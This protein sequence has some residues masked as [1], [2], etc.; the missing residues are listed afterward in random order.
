MIEEGSIEALV[1]H[2]GGTYKQL[3]ERQTL[4]LMV[5]DA[6]IVDDETGF[7]DKADFSDSLVVE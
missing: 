3:F 1:Q 4:R 2:D 5:D 6:K 7:D